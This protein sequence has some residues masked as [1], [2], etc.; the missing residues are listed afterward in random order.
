MTYNSPLLINNVIISRL[1]YPSIA[2]ALREACEVESDPLTVSLY[3]RFLSQT[4]PV[5]SLPDLADL[6]LGTDFFGT[7]IL[8]I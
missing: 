3:I 8:T 6:A 5:N 4:C 2:S 7:R 1:A